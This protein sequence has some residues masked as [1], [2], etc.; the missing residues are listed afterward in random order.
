MATGN[1]DKGGERVAVVLSGAVAR[2]A[3]QAGALAELIPALERDQLTPTI[4][5]GTSAGGINAA[6]WG[7]AAH[8]GVQAAIE[9][10]LDVWHGD[11]SDVYLPLPISGLHAAAQFA[12]GAL[13]GVG[14]G[15]TSLLDTSPLRR[16]ADEV[17]QPDQL[18]ANVAEGV[19]EAV[20]VVAT[21][22]PAAA[23]PIDVGSGRSVLFLDEH[24]PSS[25]VGDETHALDVVRSPVTVDQVLASST[26]PIAFP[27]V[28]VSTPAG[29]VG[30][31]LDGGVRLNT[32]LHPAVGLGATK[33][34]VVSATATAYGPPPPPDPSSQTPDI[35]DA[36]AQ[37][38]LAT[39]A[40]RTAEDLL[41]L[42]RINRLVSQANLCDPSPQ[43][44]GHAGRPFRRIE[45]MTVSPPPGEMGRIAAEV[46]ERSTRGLRWVTDL[47]NWMIGRIIRG[48]GERGGRRELLSYLLFDPEYFASGI[49]LGRLAAAQALATGWEL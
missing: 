14:P 10:V 37:V 33:I 16:R 39:L 48:L 42:R 6:L 12:A 24:T 23:G 30:W 32:P 38:L 20:G 27:P 35:A 15:A 31:Y 45:L 36:A 28:R 11:D 41:T 21:S 13:F 8:R 5:L 40:D 1:L 4:W 18:A 46:F 3:F 17:L 44:T 34:V 9:A 29:A 2:G 7:G 49:E 43:L 47:D 26:F 25:Y 19:L 22:T